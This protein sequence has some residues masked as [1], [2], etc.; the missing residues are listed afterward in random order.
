[1]LRACSSSWEI[2]ASSG[3]VGVANWRKTVLPHFVHLMDD[4]TL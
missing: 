3:S 4:G 2:V 1:M